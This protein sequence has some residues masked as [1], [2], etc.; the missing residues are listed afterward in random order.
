M[1]PENVRR[2]S[3]W[4]RIMKSYAGRRSKQMISSQDLSVR[5]TEHPDPR[6]RAAALI[7]CHAVWNLDTDRTYISI[8]CRIIESDK[9]EL[10]RITATE[11]LS[12]ALSNTRNVIAQKALTQLVC[13]KQASN[14]AR[15]SAYFAMREIEN[16]NSESLGNEC[17]SE[18]EQ[19]I[20][21]N[22]KTAL[23]PIDWKFVAQF[24]D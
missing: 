5:N 11:I 21:M 12:I 6:I 24:L 4:I 13:D 23:R 9:D 2:Q 15:N 3:P 10:P 20:L 1:P 7:S 14:F 16:G 19:Y 17:R 22:G 8:C 18:I